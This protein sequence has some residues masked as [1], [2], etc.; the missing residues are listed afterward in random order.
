LILDEPTSALDALTQVQVLK[1]IL[2]VQRDTNAAVLYISHD[3]VT[4]AMVCDR[5]AVLHEGKIVEEDEAKSL[6]QNPKHLYTQSVVESSTGAS[7][8]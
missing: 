2:R 8:K 7:G 4:T 5:I 6:L 3:I 1:M